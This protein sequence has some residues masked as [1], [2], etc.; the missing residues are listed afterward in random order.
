M[1]DA[2]C[3]LRS[4]ADRHFL[5][6]PT[7]DSPRTGD[8]LF[9]GHHPWDFL[10]PNAPDADSVGEALCARLAADPHLGVGEIGLDRLKVRDIPES[11]VAAFVRQLEAAAAFGRPVVLHGAKCWGRVVACCRPF[12]GKIP[13]FLFHGFSRSGGLLPEMVALG[14][15]VSVGPSVLNDHA[16]NYRELVRQIPGDRLLLESDR[17]SVEET[18][19][20]DEILRGLAAVLGEEPASLAARLDANADAFVASL[21]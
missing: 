14:G 16:V 8:V 1:T 9:A 21:V 20:C 7:A 5:C 4:D 12:A 10:S 11:M 13:A 17:T 15:Y 18:P 2:H 6:E 3:H 19:S